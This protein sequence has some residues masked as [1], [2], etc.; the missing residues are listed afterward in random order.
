MICR[1][2]IGDRI[3]SVHWQQDM[4]VLCSKLDN[5][6]S[7]AAQCFGSVWKAELSVL[8]GRVICGGWVG[9]RI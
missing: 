6:R 1:G 9:D 7:W 3:E 8:K 2:R 4:Q 5:G